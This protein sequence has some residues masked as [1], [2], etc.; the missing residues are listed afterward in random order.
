M[1]I[2][3]GLPIA[4]PGRPPRE[5]GQWA[6]DSER[7]GFHSLGSI[8]RLV[9]DILDPLVSLGVAAAVTERVQLFTS[10]LN[11]GWRGNPVLFAKQLA[12]VD[13]ISGGRLTA[14]LGIGGW[15]DD[16]TASGAPA[17]GHGKI[18]DDTL[19][20]LRR[21]WNGEVKG[22]SGPTPLPGAGRP[23]LLIGGLAQAGFARA[24][25]FGE[26]WVAPVLGRDLLA[27]GVK[28]VSEEWARAD[29]PGRPQILT[30]RYFCCGPDAKDVTSEYVA[31][32]YGSK[33]SPY[34]GPVRADCLDSD[35]RLRDELTALSRAGVDDLVLYPA[36]SS[37]DQ[38]RLLAEAL[39]RVGARRA[40]TFEFT[41]DSAPTT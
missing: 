27:N 13:L 37:L 4:V 14:G 18:F 10:V 26:G 1:K 17:K 6:Q 15:P 3:I 38:V 32:Y 40:P 5:V 23:R 30:A 16:F 11:V 24:A 35:E 25:R 31:H 33:E 7:L 41:A 29:R 12:T 22:D 39:E 20:E 9:Y 28:A 19:T 21:V 34:Y 2:G 8:D 36:S